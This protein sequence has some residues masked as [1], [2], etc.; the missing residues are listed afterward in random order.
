ML[1]IAVCDDEKIFRDEIK[2][3]FLRFQKEH[4]MQMNVSFFSNGEALLHAHTPDTQLVFL[5]IQMEGIDGI[6]TAK[7]LRMM[8]SEVIII[9]ITNMVSRAIDGY[10][11]H[12]WGFVTKPVSYPEFKF[13]LKGAIR[14]IDRMAQETAKQISIKNGPEILNLCIRDIIYCEV[15]KHTMNIYTNEHQISFRGS[16]KELEEKLSTHGFLRPHT[17]YLVNIRHVRKIHSGEVVLSS[18]ISVPISQKRR[19]EF[20]AEMAEYLGEQI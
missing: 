18:R 2:P 16:M 9:F 5:D 14:Q 12:A 20:L 13:Q 11:V 4:Q 3:H 6:E 19:K 15:R 8:D 1:N 17:S 7:K 10:S